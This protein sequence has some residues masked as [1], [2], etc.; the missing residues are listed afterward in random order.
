MKYLKFALKKLSKLIPILLV[1]SFFA[2]SA[3]AWQVTQSYQ[4]DTL[5]GQSNGRN[6][7]PYNGQ[8]SGW[9]YWQGSQRWAHSEG[10]YQR[11]NQ[12]AINWMNSNSGQISM[13]YHAFNASG[14]CGNWT[15]IAWHW[16]TLPGNYRSN[17]LRTCGY[18]EVRVIANKGLLTA[19]N[20]YA[21]QTVFRDTGAA[22]SNG[23]ITA[24]T[25]WIT[26]VTGSEN[27]HQ[28]YCVSTSDDIA[29]DRF[30]C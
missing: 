20:D 6:W 11:W 21:S 17:P 10:N 8:M 23:R 1:V 9:I 12:T 2:S 3:Y 28:H 16:S 25:Y 4:A 30:N 13:T 26:T 24:D 7:S 15:G 18:N 19:G 22:R 5:H 29:R 14:G 27:Y